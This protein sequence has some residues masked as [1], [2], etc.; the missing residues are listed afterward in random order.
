MV[1]RLIFAV[2]ALLWG[3]A[4][5]AQP[6]GGNG[7]GT[8]VQIAPNGSLTLAAGGTAQLFQSAGSVVGCVVVNPTTATEQGIG[9]AE[10]IWVNVVGTAVQLAGGTSIPVEAGS[11]LSIGPTSKAISWI[12]ATTGHLIAGYCQ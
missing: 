12:A 11:S 8:A 3:G 5:F 7:T 4:A 6:W 10:V 9:A 1:N 2:A